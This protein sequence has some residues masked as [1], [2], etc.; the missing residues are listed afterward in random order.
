MRASG[1]TYFEP[2]SVGEVLTQPDL[3][4]TVEGTCVRKERTL[5]PDVDASDLSVLARWLSDVG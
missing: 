5:T 4:V 1:V 2:L 3:A